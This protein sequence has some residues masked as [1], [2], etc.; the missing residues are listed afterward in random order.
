[1]LLPGGRRV[2]GVRQVRVLSYA[3]ATRCPVLTWAVLRK[4]GT[5]VGGVLRR[6]YAKSGTEIGGVR[7]RRI[8]NFKA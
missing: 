3:V 2:P 5:D 4:S 6:C 1:M 7:R 8:M